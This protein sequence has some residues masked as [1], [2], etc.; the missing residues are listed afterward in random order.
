M[1]FLGTVFGWDITPFQLIARTVVYTIL[2]LLVTFNFLSLLGNFMEDRDKLKS[3]EKQKERWEKENHKKRFPRWGTVFVVQLDRAASASHRPQLG[4]EN[5][6]DSVI[7]SLY[8]VQGKL[9]N[10]KLSCLHHD[11]DREDWLV[12]VPYYKQIPS[13]SSVVGKSAWISSK[14]PPPTVPELIAKIRDGKVPMTGDTARLI[15]EDDI[16][17]QKAY[18]EACIARCD[19]ENLSLAHFRMSGEQIEII[20]NLVGCPCP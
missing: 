15:F 9:P 6:D 17:I 20:Y 4:W 10:E 11:E 19:T 12:A 13:Y 14:Y 7:T 3:E 8:F 5:V 18:A 1:I 16:A 2:G